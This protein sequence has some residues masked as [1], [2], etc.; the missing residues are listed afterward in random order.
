M[1]ENRVELN[2]SNMLGARD[3]SNSLI[4]DSMQ[5]DV[6]IEDVNFVNLVRQAAVSEHR[7]F[8]VWRKLTYAL[9]EIVQGE[10]DIETAFNQIDIRDCVRQFMIA[11]TT[12]DIEDIRSK[13]PY[14]TSDKELFKKLK[15]LEGSFHHNSVEAGNDVIDYCIKEEVD[16]EVIIK[17]AWTF[18]TLEG[19]GKV[20]SSE[21]YIFNDYP[22]EQIIRGYTIAGGTSIRDFIEENFHGFYASKQELMEAISRYPGMNELVN[23]LS[24]GQCYE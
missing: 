8:R 20:Y 4:G 16:N 10:R 14:G 11:P 9:S 18:L 7:A 19:F 5:D 17:D 2:G 13:F 23:D 3:I 15:E 1:V 22:R 24:D 12:W 21:F 6:Q